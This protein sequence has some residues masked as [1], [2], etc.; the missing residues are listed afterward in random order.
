MHFWLKEHNLHS[1]LPILFQ[2]HAAFNHSRTDCKLYGPSEPFPHQTGRRSRSEQIT[3]PTATGKAWLYIFQW[4]LCSYN[5]GI[6]LFV[7]Q[8]N[9]YW[10][11]YVCGCVYG[12]RKAGG[13]IH[14]RLQYVVSKENTALKVSGRGFC[15]FFLLYS[16]IFLN[17]CN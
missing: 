16:F 7:Q 15:Q 10:I 1:F 5:L 8:I 13:F 14:V 4:P 11:I 9:M 12:N 3:L 17:C 2:W 6:R